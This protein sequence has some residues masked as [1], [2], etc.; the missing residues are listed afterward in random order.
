MELLAE[1]G[2]R[3]TQTAYA[4]DFEKL[5]EFPPAPV[6]ERAGIINGTCVPIRVSVGCDPFHDPDRVI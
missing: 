4:V 2:A 5:A 3:A 1:D 6:L